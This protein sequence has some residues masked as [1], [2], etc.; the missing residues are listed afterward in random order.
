MPWE[1]S[2]ID[3]TFGA[4]IHVCLGSNRV[5]FPDLCY[6]RRDPNRYAAVVVRPP[7]LV[8]SRLSR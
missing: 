8:P 6:A 3:Q 2:L 7:P 5:D 1:A 4:D